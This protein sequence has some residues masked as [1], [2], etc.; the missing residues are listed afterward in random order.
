MIYT[1][2]VVFRNILP[3]KVYK[4]FLLLHVAILILADNAKVQSQ[5]HIN[6]TDEYLKLFVQ[7]R[8]KIYN[9]EL[10][11]YNV[12]NLVQITDDVHKFKCLENF[13]CNQAKNILRMP[14]HPLA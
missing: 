11:V 14:Y 13:S 10:V 9:T 1:G 8:Q 12:H 4:H 7:D 2:P 6:Y 3:L 5:Q